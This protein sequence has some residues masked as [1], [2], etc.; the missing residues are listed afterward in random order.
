M[1]HNSN[2]NQALQS[3]HRHELSFSFHNGCGINTDEK[4][5][6]TVCAAAPADRPVREDFT[7]ISGEKSYWVFLLS[8]VLQAIV[9]FYGT[10]RRR[11]SCSTEV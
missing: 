2:V 1:A 8:L 10:Q 5:P 9:V 4:R 3:R 7:M 6:L 11:A